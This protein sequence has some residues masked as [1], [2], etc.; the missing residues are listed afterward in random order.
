LFVDKKILL[1]KLEKDLAFG[2]RFYR[3]L[4]MLLADRLRTTLQLPSYKEAGLGDATTILQDELDPG[5][6]QATSSAGERFNRMLKLL[7][8]GEAHAGP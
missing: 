8:E 4:S 5:I 7:M 1:Q 6:L 2:C 3:A